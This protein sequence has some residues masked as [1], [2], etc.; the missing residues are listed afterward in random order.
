MQSGMIRPLPDAPFAT[1]LSPLLTRD[2]WYLLEHWRV[3]YFD[4][5]YVVIRARREQERALAL[6]RAELASLTGVPTG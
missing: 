1:D 5:V 2:Y 4:Y 6:L 3:I